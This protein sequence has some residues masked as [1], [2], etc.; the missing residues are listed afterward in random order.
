MNTKRLAVIALVLALA[1]A[2]AFNPPAALERT[3]AATDLVE[4]YAQGSFAAMLAI[5]PE[6]PAATPE[7]WTFSAPDGNAGV[8]W[9]SRPG[10]SGAWDVAVSTPAAPFL[11][12]G[13][14]PAKLPEGMFRDGMLV[15]ALPATAAD[16]AP[17]PGDPAESFARLLA[18]H[19]D[20]V[21][22]HFQ[23]GHFGI[24]LGG[25]NLLE[26][27]GDPETNSLDLVFALD[28]A[29]LDRA[30]VDKNKLEGWLAGTV[31]VHDPA[32]RRKLEVPKYLKPFNLM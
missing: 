2:V 10:A 31:V 30:G 18:L 26:W 6:K 16:P 29:P 15:Y 3:L 5:L 4:R 8:T 1:A 23:L 32:S 21:A 9:R 14:D 12:A 17:G 11:A 25:G 28:P 27:A 7:G 20:R 13:L 24:D 22:Y 19:R